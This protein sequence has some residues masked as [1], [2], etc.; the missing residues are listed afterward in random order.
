MNPKLVGSNVIDAIPVSGPCPNK[1]RQCY[2]N[3]FMAESP[4][5]LPTVEEAEGK[6]VRVNS[7]HDSNINKAEV[8]ESA[9]RYTHRFFNTS[10]PDIRFPAPVVLTINPHEY[11]MF[12]LPTDVQKDDPDK[13]MFVRFRLAS[14]NLWLA[15]SAIRAWSLVGV[16]IVLTFM[17]YYDCEPPTSVD[18]E[19]HERLGNVSVYKREKHIKHLAWCPTQAFME[20]VMDLWTKPSPSFNPYVFMCGTPDSML[21]KDCRNCERFYWWS[22][23]RQHCK[24]PQRW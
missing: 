6:I 23:K 18:N 1:C 11:E 20:A 15:R 2:Y 16:P 8:I 14:D 9:Q 21:C 22:L 10:L 19:I 24:W 3:K 5:V 12:Y 13:L 17:R 7:G 4:A